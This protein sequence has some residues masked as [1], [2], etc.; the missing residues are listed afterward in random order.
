MHRFAFSVVLLCPLCIARRLLTLQF[1]QRRTRILAQLLYVCSEFGVTLLRYV[2]DHR[3]ACEVKRMGGHRPLPRDAP[4][5]V[6]LMREPLRRIASGFAHDLHDCK[7]LRERFGC[8]GWQ[9]GY[10]NA[11]AQRV[12]RDVGVDALLEYSK[13]VGGCAANLLTGRYCDSPARALGRSGVERAAS[14]LRAF[15]F[16]GLTDRWTESVELFCRMT[17]T[18]CAAVRRRGTPPLRHG[19]ASFLAELHAALQQRR[20]ATKD[21]AVYAAAVEKFDALQRQFGAEGGSEFRLD[22]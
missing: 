16:V 13:C 1:G 14:E 11:C 6:T 22:G 2:R 15:A 18:D 3:A 10:A 20:V 4:N 7:E 12:W 9:P 17:A 8:G 5:R 19:N 21:D